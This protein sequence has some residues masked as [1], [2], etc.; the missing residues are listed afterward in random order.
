MAPDTQMGPL[1][2]LGLLEKVDGM[3]ARAQAEGAEVVSGGGR[4]EVPELPGGYFY[5]PTI[6]ANA[7]PDAELPQEEVF[8]PVL[9]VTPFDGDDEA[10]ALAN[11][12]RY[13]LAAGVWTM[14]I[15]RAHLVARRLQAGT[16]FINRYRGLVPHSPFG[17]YKAS[18][19]GRANGVDAVEEYLQTKSVWC[20]LGAEPDIFAGA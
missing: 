5:Q 11:G 14:N 8:G 6:I 4:A 20:E 19:I 7:A 15:Q 9:A 18:G 13:G 3:V 17:G 12:T 2:T 16:V 10:V 1:A